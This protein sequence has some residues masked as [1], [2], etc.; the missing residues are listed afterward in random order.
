MI[1]LM[2]NK[3]VVKCLERDVK[4][5]KD[6]SNQAVKTFQDLVKK[7]LNKPDFKVEVEID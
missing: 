7:D 1:S 4:L 5:I 2:E 3:V 6:V